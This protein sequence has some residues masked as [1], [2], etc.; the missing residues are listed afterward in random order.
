MVRA[1]RI[2]YLPQQGEIQLTLERDG[3]H[4]TTLRG[5]SDELAGAFRQ[6][7]DD[8]VEQH[9]AKKSIGV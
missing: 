2:I 4:T 8:Y 1:L 5:S 9:Y 6:L 7:V 3:Q